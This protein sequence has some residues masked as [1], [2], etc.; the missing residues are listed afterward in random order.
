M[1]VSYT[2]S[3][4]IDEGSGV[5]STGESLPQGQRWIYA[6]DPDLRRGL[7]SFDVRNNLSTNFSYSPTWG[8][9]LTGLSGALAKGWQINGI[10]TISDA[11][12]LTVLD[13]RTAQ[14]DRIGANEGL[15]PDLIPAGNSNPVLGG[16]DLYF[17][18]TQF[19]PSRLG[20]FGTLPAQ[21]GHRTGTGDVRLVGVQELRNGRRS[22]SSIC[23]S[24]CSISSTAR[25]SARRT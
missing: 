11:T 9:N 10:L 13:S 1:Q 15:R 23:G 18:P 25:I 22:D 4:A 7:S 24:R 17:D 12:P 3:K 2:F 14:D 16:P 20:F 19:T 21:H 8:A 5:T 6:Y